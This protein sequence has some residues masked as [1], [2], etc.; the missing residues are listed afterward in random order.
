MEPLAGLRRLT[1]VGVSGKDSDSSEVPVWVL[2]DLTATGDTF[3]N[4]RFVSH[5]LTQTVAHTMALFPV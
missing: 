2:V 1:R 5:C 3:R 4:H